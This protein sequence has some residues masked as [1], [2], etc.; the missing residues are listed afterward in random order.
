MAQ[1]GL[2]RL[3]AEVELAG[4]LGVGLALDDEPRDL[5]LA[6]GQRLEAGAVAR[7]RAGAAVDAP[8]EPAE[9]AFGLV[10]VA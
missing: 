5:E 4:D 10:A 3:L 2:D 1:V 7:A 8:P 9:L 6:F